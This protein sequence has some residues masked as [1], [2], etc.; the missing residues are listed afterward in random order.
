MLTP[1]QAPA[2]AASTIQEAILA[3]MDEVVV[4]SDTAGRIRFVN[5]AAR[6]LLGLE[7][8]EQFEPHMR[9]ACDAGLVRRLDGTAIHLED[10]PLPRAIREGAIV[11]EQF[12]LELRGVEVFMLATAV[13]LRVEG[14]LVG[15]LV[16]SRDVTELMQL[17][18]LK[19]QFLAVAAHELKTPLAIIGA[20]VEALALRGAGNAGAQDSLARI[21]RGLERIDHVVT[22]LLDVSE[23]QLGRFV[24][25]REPVDL[26]ELVERVIARAP[27]KTRDRV[28]LRAGPAVM[29]SADR[30]RIS[31]V[32]AS[33]LS[34]AAKYSHDGGDVVVA[35]TRGDGQAVVSVSDTGIGIPRRRQRRIFQRFYRAHADTPGDRGSIG[36][37]LYLAR[38]FVL[39]HGG[40]MWFESAEGEGST[41][42]FSL[43]TGA[44]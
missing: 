21:R 33:L 36:L 26:R 3:T 1:I 42:S 11:R 5:G 29:V 7:R 14:R 18:R 19:D 23:L 40:Q 31:Q 20:G 25:H 12:V 13:P 9:A 28:V 39:S 38:E 41:F 8:P 22:E 10:L 24:I 34:N 32:V 35:M 30:L 17:D 6:A 4:V 16:V 37:G 43:P 15:G 27:P 2:P 44:D